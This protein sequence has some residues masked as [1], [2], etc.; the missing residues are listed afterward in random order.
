MSRHSAKGC[1]VIKVPVWVG[2]AIALT[3]AAMVGI[4]LPVIALMFGGHSY[5]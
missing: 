2:I 1:I 5:R 4:A 3:I